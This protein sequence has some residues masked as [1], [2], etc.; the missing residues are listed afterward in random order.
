[1][2]VRRFLFE[3]RLGE[4]VLV[5]LERHV[6]LAIIQADWLAGQRCGEPRSLGGVE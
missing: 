6:G 5:F 4:L 1:M 3:T 2:F